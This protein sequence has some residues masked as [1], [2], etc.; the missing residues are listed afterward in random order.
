MSYFIVDVAINS[1]MF[2]TITLV[3]GIIISMIPIYDTSH[4]CYHFFKILVSF[5][6]CS[7]SSCHISNKY[8][9]LFILVSW[10]HLFMTRYHSLFLLF[11]LQCLVPPGLFLV[12]EY[13]QYLNI[14][15]YNF[16]Y[17]WFLLC[18]LVS[19]IREDNGR[20]LYTDNT[21]LCNRLYQMI[22]KWYHI[23]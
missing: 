23:V 17:L 11:L 10:Y 1:S 12:L 8:H 13:I 15:L 3:F 16:L 18:N 14:L 2:D 9:S 20:R 22:Y 5:I 6:Y 7:V 21:N 4:H 19:D